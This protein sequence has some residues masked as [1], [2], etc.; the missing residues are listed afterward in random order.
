M[1]KGAP[2]RRNR[3]IVDDDV[4]PSKGIRLKTDTGKYS[5]T[6]TKTAVQLAALHLLSA[7]KWWF[8]PAGGFDVQ[9]PYRIIRFL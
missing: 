3:V 7:G 9:M 4:L 2:A 5:A 8:G 6:L 1:V